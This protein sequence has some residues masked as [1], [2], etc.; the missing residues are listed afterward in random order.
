MT[1]SL[2]KVHSLTSIRKEQ[3]VQAMRFSNPVPARVPIPPIVELSRKKAT[4]S[5]KKTLGFVVTEHR[6][7]CA[8]HQKSKAARRFAAE[9]WWMV[10][11]AYASVWGRP[12]YMCSEEMKKNYGTRKWVSEW[13]SIRTELEWGKSRLRSASVYFRWKQKPWIRWINGRTRIIQKYVCLWILPQ[14][15]PDI[16]FDI[17]WLRALEHI[18]Q[19]IP[20]GIHFPLQAL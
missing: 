6:Y 9:V 17:Q 8:T 14:M 4:R 3:Q 19:Y 16:H 13:V 20:H 7:F 18:F 10:E 15:S 5:K 12:H 11:Y 1:F 2:V